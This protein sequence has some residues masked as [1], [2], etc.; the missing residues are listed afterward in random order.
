MES[1]TDR[2][3]DKQTDKQT[4]REISRQARGHN[5]NNVHLSITHQRPER[6]LDTY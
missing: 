5:N 3:G 4:E 6:S 2:Q 1:H